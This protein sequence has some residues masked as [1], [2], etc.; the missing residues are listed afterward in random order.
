MYMYNTYVHVVTSVSIL[1]LSLGAVYTF[2]VPYEADIEPEETGLTRSQ[3]KTARKKQKRKENKGQLVFEVE[4]VISGVE[5]LSLEP[6]EG[7][8]ETPLSTHEACGVS[9]PVDKEPL[10][11]V[12][13]LRK[14]LKQ[15][16][17][18][19]ARIASGDIEKP[20][21]DQLN[22]IQK[23]GQFLE[24]LGLLSREIDVGA[25]V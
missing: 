11:A 3:K 7:K 20:D 22:K 14:K 15:I 6:E 9:Q 17:E 2:G 10:K 4:E 12:R 5:K 18:L 8:S 16:A 23:K 1:L 24:E 19:E 13:A 25:D 21:N